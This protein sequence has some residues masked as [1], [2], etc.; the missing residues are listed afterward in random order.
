MKG[1]ERVFKKKNNTIS[2]TRGM[3]FN[4]PS[5]ANCKYLSSLIN[6][7]FY[8]RI[9][10]ENSVISSN[11]KAEFSQSLKELFHQ[12]LWMHNHL[13]NLSENSSVPKSTGI[14]HY[15]ISA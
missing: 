10:P 12:E 7:D 4:Q 8:F 11:F 13:T 15:F 9:S 14:F 5:N 3:L 1:R 2:D 6:F